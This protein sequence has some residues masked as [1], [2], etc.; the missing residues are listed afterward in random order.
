MGKTDKGEPQLSL[1]IHVDL[2]LVS[3]REYNLGADPHLV[4]PLVREKAGGNQGAEG[5]KSHTLHA[6][7]YT[8]PRLTVA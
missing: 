1:I 6:I 2:P 8:G 4:W 3:N 5:G 7:E